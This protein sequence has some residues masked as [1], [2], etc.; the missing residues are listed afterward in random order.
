MKQFSLI[1]LLFIGFTK[2]EAQTPTLAKD[3]S[4]LLIGERFP[5]TNLTSSLANVVSLNSIIKEKPTVV[6][7]YR[8]GWCPYC[9]RHLADIRKVEDSIIALGYQI[10]AIS[11]DAPSQLHAMSNEAKVNYS[12]YS[13][14]GCELMKKIGIAFQMPESYSKRLLEYSD[15]KNSSILP[16][17]SVFILNTDGEILFEYINPTYSTR[18]SGSL[19]LGVIKSL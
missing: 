15:G 6:I 5:N 7:F 10:I 9:Q 4:P 2:L 17:P 18:I 14:P 16:V 3:I 8:G 19:L 13:D 12:L 11:P 1:L